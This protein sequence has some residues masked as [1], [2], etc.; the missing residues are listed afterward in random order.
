ML[1]EGAAGQVSLQ[2]VTDTA[3]VHACPPPPDSLWDLRSVLA[4]NLV[5]GSPASLDLSPSM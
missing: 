3:M 2:R 1:G 5:F 4:E